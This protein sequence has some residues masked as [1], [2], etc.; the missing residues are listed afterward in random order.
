[1][2]KGPGNKCNKRTP[3]KDECNR[4]VWNPYIKRGK[5]KM[6]NKKWKSIC[7][8][9]RQECVAPF[10]LDTMEG[11]SQKCTF[12]GNDAFDNDCCFILCTH[13]DARVKCAPPDADPP[14]AGRCGCADCGKL[15]C[16]PPPTDPPG[17][18]AR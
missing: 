1:M 11:P 15:G 14:I 9:K 18:A 4:L 3:G 17:R 5:G 12:R 10:N 6:K 8:S 2:K 16:R 13:P 7:L